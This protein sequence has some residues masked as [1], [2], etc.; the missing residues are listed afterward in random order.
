MQLKIKSG[1]EIGWTSRQDL[2]N[3]AS[4]FSHQLFL[5]AHANCDIIE[6]SRIA[7][8]YASFRDPAVGEDEVVSTHFSEVPISCRF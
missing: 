4:L 8:L 6:I 3:R 1:H 7:E 2:V 5:I